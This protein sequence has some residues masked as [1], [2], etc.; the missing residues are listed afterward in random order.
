MDQHGKKRD[1]LLAFLMDNMKEMEMELRAQSIVLEA[2]AQKMIGVDDLDK[3]LTWARGS[4][5]MLQYVHAKYAMMD[6]LCP[7]MGG[8]RLTSLQEPCVVS[9]RPN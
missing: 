8:E 6:E 1:M 5:A 9:K 2:V 3:A 4:T 7:G